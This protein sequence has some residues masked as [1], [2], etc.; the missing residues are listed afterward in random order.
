MRNLQFYT[1]QRFFPKPWFNNINL[2]IA[3]LIFVYMLLYPPFVSH[4]AFAAEIRLF[5]EFFV[6]LILMGLYL[7]RNDYKFSQHFLWT[8][9]TV[10]LYGFLGGD[11]PQQVLSFFL[12]MLFLLVILRALDRN[13]GVYLW[14]RQLWIW[15]WAAFFFMAVLGVLGKAGGLIGFSAFPAKTAYP[16]QFHPLVGNLLEKNVLGRLLPRYTGY[17]DEPGLFGLFAGINYFI[18]RDL[19]TEKSRQKVWATFAL[20]AAVLSLSYSL[21]LFLVLYFGFLWTR[22]VRISVSLIL[23]LV[24]AIALPTIAYIFFNPEALPNSSVLDRAQS[25]FN[26]LGAFLAADLQ[27]MIFG[28]GILPLKELIEGGA[29]SGLLQILFARGILLTGY[30]Y[31]LIYRMGRHNG[32]LMLFV[33]YYSLTFDFFWY[34]LF[35]TGLALSFLGHHHQLESLDFVKD[36]HDHRKEP[37]PQ[38][39]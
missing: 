11:A 19:F 25:I 3:G 31:W 14:V 37:R 28:I 9:I 34:P 30:F 38:P 16:Y 29:T 10:G 1:L 12:K 18:A 6:I 27:Q 5:I 26:A 32:P 4:V 2:G 36:P 23:T 7:V 15:L 17:F 22:R 13:L 39:A 33:L 21:Y 8:M 20:V 24:A 35:L